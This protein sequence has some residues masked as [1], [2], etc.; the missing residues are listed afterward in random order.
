MGGYVYDELRSSS[1]KSAH[2]PEETE[3]SSHSASGH[4]TGETSNEE[5]ESEDESTEL[6]LQN[7]TERKM[8]LVQKKKLLQENPLSSFY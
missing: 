5:A 3:E 4:L 2:I 7:P 8:S 1:S 6:P